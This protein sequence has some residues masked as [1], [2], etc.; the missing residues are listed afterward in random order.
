MDDSRCGGK[1]KRVFKWGL[2]IVALCALAI[3]GLIGISQVSRL[4]KE[5]SEFRETLDSLAGVKIGESQ[6]EILY[7]LGIPENVRMADFNPKDPDN[8]DG[9][10]EFPE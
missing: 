2:G 10:A 5:Y 7:S 8:P 6:D 3:A 1:M 9:K 4:D